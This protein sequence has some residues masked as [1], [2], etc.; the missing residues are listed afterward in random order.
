M[1]MCRI[2]TTTQAANLLP[3][4]PCSLGPTLFYSLLA[5]PSSLSFSLPRSLLFYSLLPTPYSLCPY[6]PASPPPPLQK[7]GL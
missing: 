7:S 4:L 6:V 3:S 5:T 1:G 2:V